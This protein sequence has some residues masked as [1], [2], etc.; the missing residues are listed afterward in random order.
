MRREVNAVRTST[1]WVQKAKHS[2]ASTAFKKY[3]YID[4]RG[5]SKY[6]KGNKCCLTDFEDY[7]GG[8]ISFGDGKRAVAGY[9]S[10]GN[11]AY[12]A[13]EARNK[14][15]LAEF[16]RTKKC[17]GTTYDDK[18]LQIKCKDK[19]SCDCTHTKKKLHSKIFSGLSGHFARNYPDKKRS[20]A[21]IQALNQ[22]EPVD[23][24]DLESLY[25][26][27]DEPSDSV[28]CII[29]YLDLSSDDDSDTDSLE[30]DSDFRVHMIN[31]I[32]HV[33]PIQED[34]PLSLAKIHLLKDAYAKP[35][36]IIAF[37]DIDVNPTKACHPGMNLD[38]YQL[39]KED[40]EKLVS[41]GI[42]EPTTSPWACEAFYV[43]KR[44]E[45]VHRKLRL[46]I[47]YQSLNHF[48]ANDK[49]PILQKKFL[50]QHLA[51]A[52]FLSKFD[53]KSGFW[54]LD[55]LLS[56]V[57]KSQ[58]KDVL[59]S[60]SR[61][62][63]SMLQWFVPHHQCTRWLTPIRKGTYVLVMFRR[64]GSFL[65]PKPVNDDG[66]VVYHGPYCFI[67]DWYKVNPSSR[68]CERKLQTLYTDTKGLMARANS[69]DPN[70]IPYHVMWNV[71]IWG[72]DH[73]NAYKW[74]EVNRQWLY[75]NFD[76]CEVET[77]DDDDDARS[78]WS[79]D[80]DEHFDP[81]EDDPTH[82]DARRSWL[83]DI[84]SL[85]ISMNYVPV[86]AGN[87]TNRIAG[88]K[89]NL[90]AG[91]KYSAVD[92]GK[93]APEVDESEASD[94]GGK[95]DQV[96]R[97]E[98]K[99]LPQQA[100]QT[101]NINRPNCFNT[102]SSPVNTVGS[103]FVNAASQIPINATGPSSSTNAFEEHSFERFFPFKNAFSVPHAPIMTP[104]DDTCIFG[105]AYDDEVLKEEVDINNVDSSYTISKATKFL[106][107]HPQEQVI[108]SLETPLQT[109]QTSKTHEEFGLLSLVYKLRRTNHKDFQNCLFACFLSQM[110]PRNQFKPYKIQVGN[111]KDEREIVIKNKARLVSQGNTQEEGMDYDKVFAPVARIEAI[112]LFLAYASLQDFVVCQMDVKSAFLYGRIEKEVYVCQPPGFEDPNFPDKVYKL[113]K[114]L[115]GLHQAPRAGLM[116][117]KDGGYFVNISEVT[118]VNP[119]IYV[120]CVKQFL[121]TAT[122]KKVNDKEQIQ[123]LVDKTKEIITED[124]I[125]SDL[126]FDDAEGTACLINEAILKN[127]FCNM[128]RIGGGFSRVITP[129]FDS[130]MVQATTDM[131]DT[132]VET[133]QASI[134]D[135]PSTSKPQKK[136]QP[137]RKQRKEAEVSHD[138]SEYEDH[139]PK[140]SSNPLPS[141]IALD[142]ETQGRTNDDEMFGVD[143]LAGEEVVMETTTGVE[144]SA[145]PITDVTKDKVT[146]AQVLPALKSTKPRVV[147]QKQEMSTTIQAAAT[148]VTTAV[149]TP[150]AK[151]MMD[152][153]RLLAERLQARERDEFSKVQKARLLVE[154][155]KKRKKHF[156]ALRD[157]E[158]RNKP[159]I[160]T[161]IK[162]Q[163]STYL[164]HMGGYK[165]SHLKG[166]S[167]DEIKELYDKDMTNVNDFL[168]MDSEAQESGTKRTAGHL[169]SDISKIQKVLIEATPISSR[170]PTII[171][172]KIHKE[173]KN[174]Y[175]KIIR[176]DGNFQVY[177][178]FKKMF[179][180][181]NRED[182][183][184]LWAIVKDKFKKEKPVN[185]MDNIIFRTL[186]TM[187]EH[188]VGD[189]IWK[190][191]QGLA[192]VKN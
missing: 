120:S 11:E 162:S 101:E 45:Q 48:L 87:Q 79:S 10:L 182:L 178:S 131:G 74:I 125:R 129:L 139:V 3:S 155:I 4:A 99:G 119:T 31:P 18:Y 173:R 186:K 133:Q 116:I 73:P 29:A 184:V 80:N 141:E 16:E 39:A 89:E 185:D 128:M 22:V 174:N 187:F 88:S 82:P 86:V 54:Q 32:P 152:A 176:A 51:D 23:V 192:E 161:Q 110:D 190:Y 169:E 113:E 92:V 43:N 9:E 76:H 91:S 168:A 34:P 70:K 63:L 135:Q 13:L 170:S 8:F 90:V 138:E 98:V 134:V 177:Q 146:M 64:P 164:R 94:N 96:S 26:L 60:H 167:F 117:A 126:R 68:R 1:C 21:L 172:Y 6:M 105:N 180:N 57:V 41:Q 118:T 104:I 166:M 121:A 163:M 130:M 140:S 78:L 62:L 158:K 85:T 12:R 127:I 165:Q 150:R 55:K 77:S 50:F 159:P 109:R 160:K 156:A 112:R 28:L 189:T 44:S 103:S 40:Y 38:H 66:S 67:H 106:K 191:Q 102:V 157:Q 36:S 153:D 137:M 142:D 100:R 24:S 65:P 49:F 33:L 136:K 15:F 95:N 75:D 84:D 148:I 183:E 42:I 179:K 46:V 2:S 30:G 124:S 47:N 53:L 83:F 144:D 188:H 35:I 37:F 14:K 19:S 17:L 108:G 61:H 111:K 151:A 154:L 27:N 72:K 149:P 69:V 52:R 143:N 93:K 122:V 115:Y 175:F 123:A 114:A 58:F 20:H 59:P 81:F 7:D 147:V 56:Y 107:D 97:S 132:Q 145:A 181:F 5:I 171:D 25:S 71:S